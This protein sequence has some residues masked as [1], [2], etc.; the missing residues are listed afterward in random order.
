MDVEAILAVQKS[1]QEITVQK[2]KTPHSDVG[3]VFFSFLKLGKREVVG[4]YYGSPVYWYMTPERN[5]M[6]TYGE[7][8]MLETAETFQVRVSGLPGRLA[9]KN[10]NENK[11]QIVLAAVCVMRYSN[12]TRDFPGETTLETEKLKKP[13]ENSVR[14]CNVGLPD[15]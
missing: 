10:K 11:V 1:V 13:R 4:Y 2:S 15:C 6:K 14:F 8:A 7:T 3:L 9:S 5:V 12:S